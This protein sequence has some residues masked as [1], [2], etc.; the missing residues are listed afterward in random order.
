M[1]TDVSS[2]AS[3]ARPTTMADL[4]VGIRRT[5]NQTRRRV[6]LAELATG[7]LIFASAS[8]SLLLVL[9]LVDHWVIGLGFTARLAALLMFL[10]GGGWFLYRYVAPLLFHSINPMYAARVIEQ[11]QPELKN[12]LMNFMFLSREEKQVHKAVLQAVRTQAETGLANIPI[13]HIVDYSKAIRLGYVLAFLAIVF[14]FYKIISPK[15]PMQTAMRVIAPWADLA[16]PSRVTI[17][18]VNPGDADIYQGQMLFVSVKAYNLSGDDTV[19]LYYTTEDQQI[20]NQPL[21]LEPGNDGIHYEANLSTGSQGIQ[22]NLSYR[23][24]AGDAET[25]KY[26]VRALEAPTIDVATVRYKYPEYT[27]DETRT[28][29]GD[30]HIRALENTLVTITASANHPIHKAYLEF[31]PRHK[32]EQSYHQTVPLTIDGEDPSQAKATFPLV[33]NTA[34]TAGKYRHYQVRFR[35]TDEALNPHPVLYDIDVIRDLPPEIEITAPTADRVEV[36][37]NQTLPI[38]FRA[39][40]PDYSVSRIIVRGKRDGTTLFEQKLLDESRSGQVIQRWTFSPRD[41]ELKPGQVI[42][43]QGEVQDDK[44]DHRGQRQPNITTSEVLEIRI[45]EPVGSA[46]NAPERA[47]DPQGAEADNPPQDGDPKEGDPQEGDPQ[48]K[49]A[50]QEPDANDP[51]QQPGGADQ[52]SEE[53]QPQDQQDEG[54]QADQEMKEDGGRQEGGDNQEGEPRQPEQGEGGQEQEGGMGQQADEPQEGQDGSGDQAGQAGGAGE[55]DQEAGA[56]GAGGN[57]PSDPSEKRGEQSDQRGGQAGRSTGKPGTGEGGGELQEGDAAPNENSKVER[58]DQPINSDGSQ[59]GDAFEKIQD[60]LK[61]QQNKQPPKSEDRANQDAA[62]DD[63]GSSG[64]GDQPSGDA[65]QDAGEGARPEVKPDAQDQ[66]QPQTEGDPSSNDAERLPQNRPDGPQGAGDGSRPDQS[67]AE[68]QKPEMGGEAERSNDQKVSE[69]EARDIG[70]DEAG[71][72]GSEGGVER[73]DDPSMHVPEQRE[74]DV[75]GSADNN[76]SGA[77]QPA[78]EN[79]ENGNPASLPDEA[80]RPRENNGEQSEKD[81]M[82]AED[83]APSQSVSEQT[84]DSEGDT[85]GEESGGGKQGGGQGAKQAGNDSA[86]ST[87]AGDE[88]AGAAQQE[89][90]GELSEKG[91]Q[92]PESDSQT[93]VSGQDKMG[94]GTDTA[95]GQSGSEES[96]EG[97]MAD[98]SRDPSQ[99]ASD[100]GR[101]GTG[102]PTGGGVEGPQGPV[103]PNMPRDEPGAEAANLEYSRKATEMMLEELKHQQ[104]QPDQELLDELGWSP[105]EFKQFVNRW[106]SMRDAAQTG[107]S[108]AAK[109]ELDDAL[110]SLGLSRGEDRVRQIE[111]SRQ[112]SGGSGDTQRSQPPSSF[113]EQ[114]RAYLKGGS[115]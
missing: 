55:Q 109:Q 101:G 106:Q 50:G 47:N 60:F 86:G 49:G 54:G 24:T 80:N 93:G 79:S 78:S 1:A 108:P 53:G 64:G 32:D 58:R 22:Q 35:T 90:E 65:T 87:S 12:S 63:R 82:G 95:P 16:R 8:I 75:G 10:A 46:E 68:G 97:P 13:D 23:V 88:G 67:G 14:G 37:A 3:S 33:L 36:P 30:G 25:R 113:I 92:G 38:T 28:Q 4:D 110:R 15:D 17:E 66:R 6:K 107:E 71:G 74:G 44:A 43:L 96:P 81:P 77:G 59:D 61:E 48:D 40:D 111:S 20:V 9:T 19:T 70:S 105:D 29:T 114:Y 104:D 99:E 69:G 91:G 102:Q 98:Q 2:S 7:L 41:L 26:Q 103:D 39:I 89:G 11:G 83:E 85:G 5:I 100:A 62:G 31:D 27:G 56:E 52:K 112:S 73:D 84:S 57:Q 42:H 94:E 76:D 18:E 21:V 34:G 72:S 45:V 51:Q 115:R